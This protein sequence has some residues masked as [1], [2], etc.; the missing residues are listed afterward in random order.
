MESEQCKIEICKLFENCKRR[1]KRRRFSLGELFCQNSYFAKKKYSFEVLYE[2]K[3]YL[4]KGIFMKQ[5]Y[6]CFIRENTNQIEL[7]K[8]KEGKLMA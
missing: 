8:I 3:A 6:C 5:L 4:V 7:K 1:L 2:K